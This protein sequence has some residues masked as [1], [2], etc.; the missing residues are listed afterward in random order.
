[1]PET[2]SERALFDEEECKFFQFFLR[3]KPPTDVM[4]YR[5]V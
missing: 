2:K 1:M 3:R 5:H 4:W